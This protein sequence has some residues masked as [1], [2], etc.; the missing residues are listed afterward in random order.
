MPQTKVGKLRELF[1]SVSRFHVLDY[2]AIFSQKQ[3]IF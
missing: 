1:D 3:K 2:T